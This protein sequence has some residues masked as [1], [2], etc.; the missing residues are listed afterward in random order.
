MICGGRSGSASVLIVSIFA[1]SL[2]ATGTIFTLASTAPCLKDTGQTTLLNSTIA[3]KLSKVNYG[4]FVFDIL[5]D[6]EVYLMPLSVLTFTF[7]SG[8]WGIGQWST[9]M[10][11]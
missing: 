2:I 4:G 10:G 8:D 5:Q 7:N 11:G 9:P 3:L 6:G 1:S